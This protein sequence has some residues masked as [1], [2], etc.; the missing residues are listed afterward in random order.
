MPSTW[1]NKMIDQGF[2]YADSTIKAMTNIFKNRVE[3][4][5]PK[6]DKKNLHQLP[7]K[8]RNL[9]RKGKGKTPTSVS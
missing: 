4:V 6:E 8:V 2:N 9:S 1:K 7:R 5:E 3:N